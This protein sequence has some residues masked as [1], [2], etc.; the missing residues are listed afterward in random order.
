MDSPPRLYR[1][2]VFSWNT[3][4]VGLCETLDPNLADFHR[5]SYSDYISGLTTWKYSCD[6]ADFY[7][8]LVELI[9]EQNP[10][11]VVIGFQED[12]YPGSY[13]HSHLLVSEMPKIGY[14]LVK[15][16]KLMGIGITTYKGMLNGDIFERGLRIS[17]YAKSDIIPS[18][19]KEEAE[20]RA[21]VGNDGQSE[22]VCSS[23]ITRG[24]GAISSYIIL[25]GFGRMA[26]VCCHLPFNAQS[27]IEERV[28]KNSMLRQNEINQVNTCFNNIIE[29]LVLFKNPNPTHVIYFGDF[30]Y[31]L[32][33]PR[34]ATTVANDFCHKYDDPDFLHDIYVMYDELYDQTTRKNIY[35]FS[36]G[37][38]NQG[39]SFVPTCKMLKSRN[40]HD[41]GSWKTGQQDQRVPSWCDRILYKTFT[42][43]NHHMVCTY[44]DR[45]DTGNVMTKS[46]HA[47]IVS[48]FDLY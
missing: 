33:D 24:K 19:E 42:E 28:H 48:V 5:S 23:F 36:E 10:D 27:L 25:P 6:I 40:H 4:S 29:N 26:F 17:I 31:R 45:F 8:Q 41:I 30:N 35:E 21:F 12:R 37:I 32:A 15:R 1:I 13:F 22:Y 46:D 11:L 18:I 43:T 20:M 16:C 38:D 9:I 14:G 3:Q 2:L 47:A 7:P 44:Y 39:P 34:P